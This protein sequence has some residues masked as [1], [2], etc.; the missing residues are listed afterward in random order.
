MDK[1]ESILTLNPFYSIGL[2][3]LKSLINLQY[4]FNNC[5]RW[6]SA[7]SQSIHN[8]KYWYFCPF[9]MIFNLHYRTT[10]CNEVKRKKYEDLID[11]SQVSTIPYQKFEFESSNT[12]YLFE[13][14]NFEQSS[15]ESCG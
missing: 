14:W 2:V 7:Y 10:F 9:F 11:K 8:A 6:W 13:K 3:E 12:V 1:F 5:Q 15:F 4:L